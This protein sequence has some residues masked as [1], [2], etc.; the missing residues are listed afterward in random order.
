MPIKTLEILQKDRGKYHSGFLISEEYL[1][2]GYEPNIV[3][4][5]LAYM[6]L[7]SAET[8]YI[9]FGLTFLNKAG[10]TESG[11]AY[12]G[13]RSYYH[14]LGFFIRSVALAQILT[15]IDRLSMDVYDKGFFMTT[16]NYH[17]PFAS[18]IGGVEYIVGF[19]MMFISLSFLLYPLE[20]Y[21][22][23]KRIVLSVIGIVSIPKQAKRKKTEETNT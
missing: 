5:V 17:P 18:M 22:L 4:L 8:L 15:L 21:L 2:M 10:A 13:Q 11:A 7:P 14:G 16:D 12:A 1:A 19:T 23:Q 9:V 20:K 3:R 6:F